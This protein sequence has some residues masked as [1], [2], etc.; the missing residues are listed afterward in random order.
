[1]ASEFEK[2]ITNIQIALTEVSVRI[3]KFIEENPDF[4]ENLEYVL[5]NPDALRQN[6]SENSRKRLS[7]LA[8]YGWYPHWDTPFAITA[9]LELPKD[10]ALLDNYMQ[11]DLEEN[12]GK[13][14]TKIVSLYPERKHVL[15]EAFE[16]HKE[17]KH[18]AC[19]P[20]L[21]SQIDGIVA[22]NLHVFLFSEHERRQ[23]EVRKIVEESGESLTNIF[24]RVLS[25]KT[26][27]GEKIKSN[28]QVKKER[29]PNRNGI[30]HGSRKHLDYGTEINSFKC[31]SLLAFVAFCFDDKIERG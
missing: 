27:F 3:S 29:A 16:L 4:I 17:G 23:E 15:E 26:Q 21:L 18:I 1:M 10:K 19:I 14:T 31:F 9:D 13:I 24:L 6:F 28:S 2:F 11:Q 7:E 12:W 20:L 5:E 22:Q 25:E 30:L 8:S